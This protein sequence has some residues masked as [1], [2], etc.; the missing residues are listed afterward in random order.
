MEEI[1]I[2]FEAHPIVA[3]RQVLDRNRFILEAAEE[4]DVEALHSDLEDEEYDE[5]PDDT[6]EVTEDET[7]T[8]ETP[9]GEEVE[10]S[11]TE[12]ELEEPPTT[13]GPD[14]YDLN[15]FGKHGGP[16]VPNNQY[17][18]KDVEILN[19]LI[20]SESDAINDYFD[21]TTNTVDTNLSR[22]YGDIGREERF[23]LEQL[24]YAKSL[25]TG[26]KYEPKDPEVKKEYEELIGQGMDEDTAIITTMDK[27]SVSSNQ[28]MSDEEMAEAQEEVQ[29]QESYLLQ[30][31]ALLDMVMEADTNTIF[32]KLFTEYS[33]RIDEY[34]QF[35][36]EEVLNVNTAPKNMTEGSNPI[37]WIIKQLGNVIKFGMKLGSLVKEHM[38]RGRL[39]ANKI[40]EWVKHNSIKAIFQK[41]YSFY[42]YDVKKGFSKDDIEFFATVAWKTTDLI[43]KACGINMTA[44][45]VTQ[46]PTEKANGVQNIEQG[47][48]YINGMQLMKTKV[49][50]T[51]A[52][53][54]Y[55]KEQLFGATPTSVAQTSYNVDQNGNYT[56]DVH[57]KSDNFY[58]NTMISLERIERAAQW[59]NQLAEHLQSMEGK[60][61]LYQSNHTLWQKS[62]KQLG[63]LAKGFVKIITAIN[64]D[65]NTML[66]IDN[67]IIQF[68]NTYDQEAKDNGNWNIDT[69]NVTFQGNAEAQQAQQASQSTQYNPNIP[70]ATFPS[71]RL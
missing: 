39:R 45:N 60:P 20:S 27:I 59:T 7:T 34:S 23:H 67:T 6:E 52:N 16:D 49:V 32:K 26:E 35:Y 36:M 53:E 1:L 46:L 5:E 13:E 50:I 55:I 18:E 56:T 68:T 4:D 44:T 58:N 33:T 30:T 40:K 9:D 3:P 48:R 31:Q 25:I 47:L 38:R 17:N 42:M 28:P 2:N 29:Q 54:D 8:K 57:F 66:K 71:Y 22:L 11:E 37:A 21:A 41:G 14:G 62:I 19:K 64:H 63:I 12:E 10:T 65:I 43:G 69:S 70:N 61:G 51:D 24:M 15:E